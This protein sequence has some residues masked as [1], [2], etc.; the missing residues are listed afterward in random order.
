VSFFEAVGAVVKIGLS[1]NQTTIRKFSL[2][3]SVKRSV[4]GKNILTLNAS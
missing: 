3:K 1:Q 4:G 2:P